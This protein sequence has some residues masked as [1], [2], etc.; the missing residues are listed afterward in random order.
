MG[1]H[2]SSRRSTRKN[3]K[4]DTWNLYGKNTSRGLRFK[5]DLPMAPLPP[6]AQAQIPPSPLPRCQHL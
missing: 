5:F 4:K 6:Q 1:N 2:D 3:N